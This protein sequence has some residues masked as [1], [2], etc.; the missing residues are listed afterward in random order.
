M[1]APPLSAPRPFRGD[2]RVAGFDSGEPALDRWL[3]TRAARNESRYSRTYVV[4]RG[5]DVRGYYTLAAGTVDRAV[6][7]G[8]L[9][10]NA[11]DSV[12]VLLLARLA[13]DRREQG[14]GLGA[15]LLA[16]AFQRCASAA[17]VIGVAAVLVHAKS[18]AARRFYLHL[19]EFI[20]YPSDS[21]ILF[22]PMQTILEA[23][24]G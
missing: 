15:D 11:P 6:A 7:P 19:A 12:P 17:S 18:D 9:R 8:R 16:D 13:V 21:R 1:S 22:L 14:Q 2:H 5:D 20:E 24:P 10:R 3:Q 23:R 4:T